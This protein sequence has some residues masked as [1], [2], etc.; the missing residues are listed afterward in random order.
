MRGL[1]VDDARVGGE[2]GHHDDGSRTGRPQGVATGGSEMACRA[3]L[4][5]PWA[6][7]RR[8]RR[9]EAGHVRVP[10]RERAGRIGLIQP[11]VQLVEAFGLDPYRLGP[12]GRHVVA[13][14]R[15]G[16]GLLRADLDPLEGDEL[17]LAVGLRLVDERLRRERVQGR[18]ADQI[19][20]HVVLAHRPD[21][22][23]RCRYRRDVAGVVR[24]LDRMEPGR[25]RG[26]SRAWSCCACAP[27]APAQTAS[28][29]SAATVSEGSRTVVCIS[30]LHRER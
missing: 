11:V 3:A 12:S 21:R 29:V 8:Y 13:E 19:E 17:V 7:S 4:D 16:S 6:V 14:D 9:T 24:L 23:A 10:V 26:R 25:R 5:R 18:V 27:M 30:D 1:G 2:V 15:R 20:V 28:T 22:A